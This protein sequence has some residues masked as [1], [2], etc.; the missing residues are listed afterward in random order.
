MLQST[1]S[2]R[3]RHGSDRATTATCDTS[4]QHFKV[5]SKKEPRDLVFYGQDHGTEI[6]GVPCEN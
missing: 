4:S 5:S 1:G 3:V 2:Q 6:T